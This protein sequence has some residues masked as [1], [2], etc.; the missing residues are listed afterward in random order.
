MPDPNQWIDPLGL[1][2]ENFMGPNMRKWMVDEQSKAEN[3]DTLNEQ[4][5]RHKAEE[6]R[7]LAQ[8]QAD[9]QKRDREL[10]AISNVAKCIL[11]NNCTLDYAICS[12]S[13]GSLSGGAVVNLHNGS[14]FLTQGI[15]GTTIP[16]EISKMLNT[17]KFNITRIC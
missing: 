8:Q 2:L 6:E 11:E 17:K 3:A 10:R 5:R 7:N 12:G 13:Q 15:N 9:G 16:N 1:N 14:V 4:A